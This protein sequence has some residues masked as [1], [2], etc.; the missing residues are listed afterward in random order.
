MSL[1]RN[2]DIA[3]NSA[4]VLFYNEHCNDLIARDMLPILNAAELEDADPE[5]D[6]IGSLNH[7]SRRVSF[8]DFLSVAQNIAHLVF[9]RKLLR[10]VF[11]IH[12]LSLR[13]L[14]TV[15]KAQECDLFVFRHCAGQITKHEGDLAMCGGPLEEKYAIARL[16]IHYIL[17]S[18]KTKLFAERLLSCNASNVRERL[19]DIL[20]TI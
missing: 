11:R 17:S 3:I 20:A 10:D 15:R 16:F 14:N 6:G 13:T 2:E 12:G 1:Q 9:F 19:D 4:I 5:L 7:S 18:N 8:E